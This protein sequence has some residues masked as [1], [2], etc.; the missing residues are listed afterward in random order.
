MARVPLFLL[1]LLLAG[2]ATSDKGRAQLLASDDIGAIYSDLGLRA[3]LVVAA[4]KDCSSDEC[5]ATA[6]F[7]RQVGEAGERLSKAAY[8][9]YPDLEQRV[10]RFEFSVPTKQ[11]LGTLSNTKGSVVIFSAMNELGMDEAALNFVVAREMGHIIGRHH[12]EN[13]G[14]SIAVSVVAQLIFPMANII[15][16]AAAVLPTTSVVTAATTSAASMLGTRVLQ[17]VYR[18]DQVDEADTIAFKLLRQTGWDLEE[19]V[20]SVGSMEPQLAQI[21]EGGWISEFKLSK[22]RLDLLDCDAPW[23]IEPEMLLTT[24]DGMRIDYELSTQ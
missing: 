17:S 14:L 8:A 18:Q 24:L 6:T 11:E 10:P 3:R 21:G 4:D 22:A 7:R 9:A 2:C 20:R 23:S 19:V 1:I 12:Q 15:R 16:G 5:E 13:T